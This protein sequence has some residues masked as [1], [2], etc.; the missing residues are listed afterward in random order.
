MIVN[1]VTFMGFIATM[2]TN[3]WT[4]PQGIGLD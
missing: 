1:L 2:E 3:L 4:C